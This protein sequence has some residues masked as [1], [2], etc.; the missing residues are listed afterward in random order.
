MGRTPQ[1]Y[2]FFPPN[3]SDE[4]LAFNTMSLFN[5]TSCLQAIVD[6]LC[7][8]STKAWMLQKVVLAVGEVQQAVQ[9]VHIIVSLN[10]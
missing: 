4:N 8:F 9:D 3:L 7:T 6:C 1:P 5:K 10:E 2:G